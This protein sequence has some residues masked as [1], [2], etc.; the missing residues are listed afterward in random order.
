[1]VFES[2]FSKASVNDLKTLCYIAPIERLRK[3]I[4]LTVHRKIHKPYIKSTCEGSKILK[5]ILVS[6]NGSMVCRLRNFALKYFSVSLPPP[7]YSHCHHAGERLPGPRE[8]T[9][10]SGRPDPGIPTPASSNTPSWMPLAGCGLFLL[11]DLLPS[12]LAV[13]LG[14]LL[15]FSYISLSGLHPSL[16]P[17][18]MPSVYFSE[19]TLVTN[20]CALCAE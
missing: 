13:D 17:K 9:G 11:A 12:Y 3:P 7:L 16:R 20:E 5:F 10:R 8:S 14:L 4:K 18:T 1:M 19:S 6:L 2:S 15:L